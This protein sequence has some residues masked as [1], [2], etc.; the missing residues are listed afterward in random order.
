[1][2]NGPLTCRA[3]TASSTGCG[4]SVA[5]RSIAAIV[6]RAASIAAHANA[7]TAP[8]GCRTPRLA[9]G[10]GTAATCR[11]KSAHQTSTVRLLSCKGFLQTAVRIHRLR[12]VAS[13]DSPHR[14]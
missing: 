8:K 2:P 12:A 4:A 14:K 9:R 5:H 1:M 3:P 13:A 6:F 11:A 7:T 10:S